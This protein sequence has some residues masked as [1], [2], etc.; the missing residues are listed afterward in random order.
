MEAGYLSR[1]SMNFVSANKEGSSGKS[2]HVRRIR[3]F[4]REIIFDTEANVMVTELACL[5]PGCPPIETAIVIMGKIPKTY[6]IDKEMKD[7]NLEDV[8]QVLTGGNDHNH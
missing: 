2:P 4:V 8:R 7:V 1:S 6:K 5:E 3:E